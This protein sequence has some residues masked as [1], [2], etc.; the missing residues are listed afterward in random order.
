M[1]SVCIFTL[2]LAAWP[3]EKAQMFN[4]MTQAQI[5]FSTLAINRGRRAVS[6][7][8]FI[9]RVFSSGLAQK[10]ATSVLPNA[11]IICGSELIILYIQ[12]CQE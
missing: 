5:A 7:G 6:V 12:T 10:D 11:A 3:S 2:I 4:G 9:Q 1:Q 8:K